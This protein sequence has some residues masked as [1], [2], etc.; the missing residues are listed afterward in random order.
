MSGGTITLSR[1]SL[2]SA[3]ST[4]G[5]AVRNGPILILQHL[6]F[7][8]KDGAV[9]VTATDLEQWVTTTIPANCAPGKP[10]MLPAKRLGELAAAAPPGEA[11]IQPNGTSAALRLGRGSFKLLTLN[12][13]DWPARSE[14]FELIGRLPGAL[15]GEALRRVAYAV[16]TEQ[17]RPILSCVFIEAVN[18]KLLATATNSHRLAHFEAPMDDGL[19]GEWLL[20]G[21]HAKSIQRVAAAHESVEILAAEN[22]Q[23]MVRGERTSFS[24]RLTQGPYPEYRRIVGEL[25]PA[26]ILIDRS[27][28]IGV[29]ERVS[30]LASEK[31]EKV[32]IQVERGEITVSAR[33]A[34]QGASEEPLTVQYSGEPTRFHVSAKYLTDAL[35]QF[36]EDEVA[37]HVIAPEYPI[38]IVSAG[39]S[40][41]AHFAITMPIRDLGDE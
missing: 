23:F 35:R 22:G 41:D 26:P 33:L 19:S 20:P 17:K 10:F 29:L 12:V 27:A 5:G 31:S 38:R 28:L 39:K 3:L 9:V 7:A 4:V 14:A 40:P 13:D 11:I 30:I 1:E 16:S 15:L 24:C 18:G 2:R 37:L 21:I 36:D 6:H 8:P 34:D 25:S 32:T